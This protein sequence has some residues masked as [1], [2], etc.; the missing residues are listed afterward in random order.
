MGEGQRLQYVEI[1]A[2]DDRVKGLVAMALYLPSA[3]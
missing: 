3:Y 1:L 2:V